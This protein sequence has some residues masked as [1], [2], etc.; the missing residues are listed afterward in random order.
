VNVRY[1]DCEVVARE[2]AEVVPL[3]PTPFTVGVPAAAPA[4]VPVTVMVVVEL[5]EPVKVGLT[6]GMEEA[7]SA[8][9]RL[10]REGV[11]E[12][13]RVMVAEALGVAL[14]SRVVLTLR[15]AQV[16]AVR[17]ML[18]EA[19]LL[20][21]LV[22]ADREGEADTVLVAVPLL[23]G[24]ATVADALRVASTV[25]V[26]ETVGEMEGETLRER[27]PPLGV[28]GA[29][30]VSVAVTLGVKV[31][32]GAVLVMLAVAEEE[33]VVECVAEGEPE[34]AAE[35]LMLTE[36]VELLEAW[37]LV[38]VEMVTVT[39][40]LMGGLGVALRVVEGEAVLLL[41]PQALPVV[42]PMAEGMSLGQ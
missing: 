5:P 14:V 13:V 32:A 23:V 21:P 17:L 18:L 12:V 10:S 29:E 25:S 24:A 30:G 7:L 11:A 34:A 16:L 39:E 42:L 4:M 35:V 19:L 41:V 6:L 15:L 3:P 38:E 33:E 36:G 8:T 9:E 28:K 1:T 40:G 26:G 20:P 22:V 31:G 27:C 2:E 37:G